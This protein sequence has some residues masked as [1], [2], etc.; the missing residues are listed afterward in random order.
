[1][2]TPTMALCLALSILFPI[3]L[4]AAEPTAEAPAAEAPEAKP[5]KGLDG[6]RSGQDAESADEPLPPVAA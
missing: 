4:R 6:A 1:M 5:V 2:K 3:A